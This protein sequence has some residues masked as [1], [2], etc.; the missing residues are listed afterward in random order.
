MPLSRRSAPR[1]ESPALLT[2]WAALSTGHCVVLL[3]DAGRWAK[4][5]GATDQAQVSMPG[6]GAGLLSHV[7]QNGSQRT[8]SISEPGNQN[9][10]HAEAELIGA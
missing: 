7:N 8:G 2:A 1:K 4:A 3:W 10:G 6:K 9:Q 5:L